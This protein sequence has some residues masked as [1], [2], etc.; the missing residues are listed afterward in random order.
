MFKASLKATNEEN[1]DSYH[2]KLLSFYFVLFEN[3]SLN[4]SFILFLENQSKNKLCFFD[5][6]RK[7]SKQTFQDIAEEVKSPLKKLSEDV[8]NKAVREAI[9]MQFV[10]IYKFWKND[11]SS[12][13][14]ETDAFI[15]KTIRVTAD[16]SNAIPTESLID[17]GKFLFKN[18]KHFA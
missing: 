9:F 7:G 12:E 10:S 13:F 5:N 6:I 4:R 18:L 17:Y 3:F 2:H 11:S 1:F 14:E 15:E 16:L 8:S